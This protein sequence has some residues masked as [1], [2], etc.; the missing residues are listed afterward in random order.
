[1]LIAGDVL[2]AGAQPDPG[3]AAIE[4]GAKQ[5]GVVA[6][7]ATK[8]DWFFVGRK[9]VKSFAD[10][11]P[12]IRKWPSGACA[13]RPIARGL[14]RGVYSTNRPWA[15]TN[16]NGK[17]LTMALTRAHRFFITRQQKPRDQDPTESDQARREYDHNRL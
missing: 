17:R 2:I 15:A 1:M 13:L 7:P 4:E 8:P 5:L 12:S 3:V 6:R 10:R 11:S 9:G 14:C 16:N